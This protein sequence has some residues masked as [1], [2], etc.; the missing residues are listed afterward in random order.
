MGRQKHVGRNETSDGLEYIKAF[1]QKNSH[2]NITV[3]S[4]SHRRD[5]DTN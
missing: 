2:T 5:L 1:V 3:I 4:I